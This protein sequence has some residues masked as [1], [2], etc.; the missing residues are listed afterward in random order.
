MDQTYTSMM[1]GIPAA[2]AI[3]LTLIGVSAAAFAVLAAIAGRARRRGDNAPSF[4]AGPAFAIAPAT[5][6]AAAP[7]PATAP[8]RRNEAVLRA[9]AAAKAVTAE[10]RA[11]DAA[12]RPAQRLGRP[13]LTRP[14]FTR[15]QTG[16]TGASRPETRPAPRRPEPEAAVTEVLEIS[17]VATAAGVTEA[18]EATGSAGGAGATGGAGGAEVVEANVVTAVIEAV[19]G[20][21][22]PETAETP[23]TSEKPDAPRSD[24]Q[25]F[26]DELAIAAARAGVTADR[27]QAE[28]ENAQRA[29]DAAWDAYEAA[30]NAAKRAIRAAAFPAPETPLTPAEYADREKYLHRAAQAAH[31]RGELD[32]DQ[33]IDALS[34]RNGFDPRLHPFEQ[35]ALL[36]RRTRDRLLR[37]YREAAEAERAAWR[38]ADLARAAQRSLDR[39]AAVAARNVSA[40]PEPAGA[41]RHIRVTTPVLSLR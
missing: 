16:R 20:P 7:D 28:W 9:L 30:E 34:H 11:S 17:K 6:D 36:R 18:T 31:A 32:T 14:R 35:D 3:W 10:E 4:V 8:V 1:S 22:A 19:D 26:A 21:G 23:D 13:K 5:G 33:L 37:V 41:S 24:E 25:R 12:K 2:L 39:E 38:E 15:P 27:R 40:R 29:V